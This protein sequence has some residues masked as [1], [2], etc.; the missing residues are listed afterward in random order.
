M[1]IRQKLLL[2]HL[3][4]IDIILVIEHL[5]ERNKYNLFPRKH[6]SNRNYKIEA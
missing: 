3:A 4:V 5:R 2:N 1:V 6:F